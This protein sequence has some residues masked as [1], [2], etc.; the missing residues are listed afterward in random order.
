ME[1]KEGITISG[2]D[3]YGK[4]VNGTVINT[5][6]VFG[7]AVIEIGKVRFEKTVIDF[8]NIKIESNI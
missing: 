5:S 3:V 4:E 1:I 8:K 2:I 6:N 7:F